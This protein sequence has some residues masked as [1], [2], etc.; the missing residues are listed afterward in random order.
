MA[1]KKGCRKLALILNSYHNNSVNKISVKKFVLLI[2]ADQQM[3]RML[4]S[5]LSE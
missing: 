3:K 2:T 1:K 4:Y 5:E